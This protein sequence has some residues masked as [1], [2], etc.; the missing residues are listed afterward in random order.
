MPFQKKLEHTVVIPSD[1]NAARAV[2][3]RIIREIEKLGY[4]SH[5]AF[6]IRLALEE[7]IVNAYK[8]GN[9]E[10]PSKRIHISYELKP[11]RVIFRIR[12]EG[13]GFCPRK[14]PDPTHPDRIPLPN[15]RGIM[16]MNAYLDQVTYNDTG[17]EVELV[18]ERS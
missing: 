18:K 13:C 12:D 9:G 4:D 6:A 11:E 15:G 1:L 3:E 5:S 14:V 10:D 16:L 2:E 8:H 7:A 17:N